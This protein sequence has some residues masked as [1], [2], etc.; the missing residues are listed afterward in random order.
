MCAI[1]VTTDHHRQS[2]R[3]ILVVCW[4]PR[5]SAPDCYRAND[6]YR[7]STMSLECPKRKACGELLPP[8]ALREHAAVRACPSIIVLDPEHSLKHLAHVAK[9]MSLFYATTSF[10]KNLRKV[11][12]SIDFDA[13]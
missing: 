5:P 8:R 4:Q 1:P 13:Y 9:R 2:A 7:Y 12:L 3:L 10:R 11:S 6:M